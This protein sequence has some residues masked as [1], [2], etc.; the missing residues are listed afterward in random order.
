MANYNHSHITGDIFTSS[1]SVR[2]LKAWR[3]YDLCVDLLFDFQH[4]EVEPRWGHWQIKWV[5]GLSLL[6]ATGHVL[7]KID[8][9][10]SDDRAATIDRRWKSW[11]A[12]K[13]R[14]WVFFEFIEKERNNILKE[15]ELGFILGPYLEPEEYEVEPVVYQNLHK[16]REAVYW[17]RH[18]LRTLETELIGAE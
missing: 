1:E 7:A 15:F 5:A 14:N 13:D 10:N 4:S 12:D 6:R 2:T 18:Q 8:C 16:F 9:E 17:W 3:P 11:K